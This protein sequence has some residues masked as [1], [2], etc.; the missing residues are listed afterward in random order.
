MTPSRFW[1]FSEVQ[2]SF[3]AR[4]DNNNP[5]YYYSIIKKLLTVNKFLHYSLYLKSRDKA[6]LLEHIS[7]L[8]IRAEGPNKEL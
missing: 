2:H 3:A 5:Q 7:Y 6:T 1:M 4:L 8:L